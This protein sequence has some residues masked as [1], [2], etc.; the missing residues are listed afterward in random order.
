MKSKFLTSAILVAGILAHMPWAHA[1]KVQNSGT[2]KR[3]GVSS[4]INLRT[5]LTLKMITAGGVNGDAMPFL[6]YC[7][8]RTV[9]SS[10]PLPDG[11]Q[12]A[13][14]PSGQIKWEGTDSVEFHGGGRV[15]NPFEPVTKVQQTKIMMGLALNLFCQ[16]SLFEKSKVLARALVSEPDQKKRNEILWSHV[17]ETDDRIKELSRLNPTLDVAIIVE[18]GN[19][20]Y[21]RPGPVDFTSGYMA[22][23]SEWMREVIYKKIAAFKTTPILVKYPCETGICEGNFVVS[24]DGKRLSIYRNGLAYLTDTVV[25]GIESSFDLSSEKTIGTTKKIER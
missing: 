19:A 13:V 15:T 18:E 7:G 10:I 8:Y 17:V 12:L 2:Q 3:E 14:F 9:D 24:T 5:E 11:M 25:G 6:Q 4:K 20:G 23:K 1:Q 16:V 21:S 22:D